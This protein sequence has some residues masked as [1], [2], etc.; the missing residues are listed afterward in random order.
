MPLSFHSKQMIREIQR[1][2][3]ADNDC[4]PDYPTVN[5]TDNVLLDL[6]VD[7]SKALDELESKVEQLQEKSKWKGVLGEFNND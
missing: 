7:L 2:Y 6:V 1:R 5:W 3:N 4:S